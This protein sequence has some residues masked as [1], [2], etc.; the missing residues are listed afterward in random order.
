MTVLLFTS[1]YSQLLNFRAVILRAT[2][3]FFDRASSA[4]SRSS[5]TLLMAM[6]WG[7]AAMQARA[8]AV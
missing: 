2:S 3:A 5:A 4:A 1:I 6:K 7:P 8:A